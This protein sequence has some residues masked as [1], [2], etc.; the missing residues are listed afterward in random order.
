L[1]PL[2]FDENNA[3]DTDTGTDKALAPSTTT[4]F[5]GVESS[6]S[7]CP[8]DPIPDLTDLM[9]K[10]L[11]LD[12]C[13]PRRQFLS[14]LNVRLPNA[15][16]SSRGGPSLSSAGTTEKQQVS[17]KK[18]QENE[19]VATEPASVTN[20]SAT[21][22][23]KNSEASTT[24]K[25]HLEYD[26]E[27]LAILKQT[28][29]WNTT[30][31]RPVSTFSVKTAEDTAKKS[32]DGSRVR[33][34]SSWVTQRFEET[35][36]DERAKR[37][38]KDDGDGAGSGQTKGKA[39]RALDSESAAHYLEIPRDFVPTVPYYTDD[40]FQG[41]RRRHSSPPVLPAMGNPQ[42]D[43]L[44]HILELTHILTRPYDPNLTQ[45]AISAKWRCSREK[46]TDRGSHRDIQGKV[47]VSNGSNQ[48]NR[49]MVID[50]E[51]E[52]DIDTDIDIEN[53]DGD[54]DRGDGKAGH[55]VTDMT[56]KGA[57]EAVDDNEIEIDDI[58]DEGDDDE[59]GDDS[60]T[61]K[62][63]EGVTHDTNEIDLDGDESEIDSKA[64]VFKKAR[65]EG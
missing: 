1:S 10:F 44:L 65:L 33:Y 26:P 48:N 8:S 24:G 37:V 30:E 27:W 6:E 4:E 22:H 32:E 20:D 14:V 16:R 23:D 35:F 55:D 17:S 61:R 3:S 19:S 28:H 18:L 56:E 43:R 62:N 64:T 40:A 57:I 31:R 9:T 50:D 34:D 7:K 11:A 2:P 45:E 54:G 47:I 58:D 15:S 46:Q 39:S 29:H 25:H 49:S 36:Q 5:H 13:L 41:N 53:E 52:I 38:E 51:N 63:S 59:V 12:K 42:T 21:S 60:K